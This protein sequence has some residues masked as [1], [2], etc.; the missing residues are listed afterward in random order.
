MSNLPLKNDEKIITHKCEKSLQNK[1]SI[2][3][4]D[5]Y[6]NYPSLSNKTWWLCKQEYDF[7]WDY[8]N[9]VPVSPIVYCPYCGDKLGK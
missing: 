5:P 2:R 4:Y 3:Y 9:L 7:E 1:M 6:P 8:T